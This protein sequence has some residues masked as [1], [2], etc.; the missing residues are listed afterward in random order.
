[1]DE[2]KVFCH[3][4]QEENEWEYNDCV[5]VIKQKKTL[6]EYFVAS[7]LNNKSEDR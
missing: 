5:V 3:E 7:D 4:I 2:A 1:M 6:R